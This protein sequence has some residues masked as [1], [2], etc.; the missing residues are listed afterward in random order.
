MS[1]YGINNIRGLKEIQDLY[2]L[3]PAAPGRTKSHQ[4]AEAGDKEKCLYLASRR[5]IPQVLPEYRTQTRAQAKEKNC[6][7]LV[8]ISFIIHLSQEVSYGER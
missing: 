5:G 2:R 1:R 8:R 7:T 6:L 4:G 3:P